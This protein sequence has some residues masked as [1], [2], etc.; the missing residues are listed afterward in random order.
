MFVRR[1]RLRNLRNI[2]KH[3]DPDIRAGVIFYLG[4]KEKGKA[5]P[6]AIQATEK[7]FGKHIADVVW[8]IC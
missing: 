8:N 7:K 4:M 2:M 5:S 1:S 3:Y 6:E